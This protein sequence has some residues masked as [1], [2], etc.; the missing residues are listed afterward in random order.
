MFERKGKY[1]APFGHCCA[2]CYQGSGAFVFI[3]DHPSGPWQGQ[4]DPL[5]P[6]HPMDVGCADG[7]VMPTPAEAHTL[8]TTAVPTP[9][10]GCQ[11]N[12][13]W[14][15]DPSKPQRAAASPMRAQ[16]N[17]VIE[18]QTPDGPQYIWTGDRWMQAPDGLKSHEPQFWAPLEFTDEGHILPIKWVDSFDINVTVPQH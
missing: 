16:A 18:V 12:G 13:Q 9:Y 17:F 3:A 5:R 6:G 7:A 8:P 14:P 2:F 11:Y 15:P 1:Y 10:Q 4:P